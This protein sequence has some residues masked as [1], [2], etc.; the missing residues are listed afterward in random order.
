TG[1]LYPCGCSRAER[2]ASARRSPD[3]GWAYDNR[4]RSRALPAGG[5][6]A[7]TEALRVRLP[8]QM[9]ALRDESGL[10]LSQSPAHE[11]GDP[12]VVRR[13]GVI[14]YQLVVVV[15]DAASGVTR[16]V[17]GRDIATSTASQVLLHELLELPVPSYRHHF[18]LLEPHGDKLAK[19]HG[20]IDVARLRTA[21]DGRA[22]CGVLALAAGLRAEDAPCSPT[23]LL[24]D[25]DW[26]RVRQSDLVMAWDGERLLAQEPD[27]VTA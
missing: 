8:D 12:I 18:L 24:A 27:A 20:S 10:D 13:D 22:L 2:R 4:C 11:L 9:V 3:G 25:F 26:S 6:R 15:D 16:V 5:W 17:R 14:A 7:A 23:D 19:L 21:Y 1:R